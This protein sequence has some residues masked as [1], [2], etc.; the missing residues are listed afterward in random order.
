ML[1]VLLKQIDAHVGEVYEILEF[2]AGRHAN[3]TAEI[4]LDFRLGRELGVIDEGGL[5]QAILDQRLHLFLGNGLTPSFIITRSN[6][7]RVA[8]NAP[9]GRPKGKLYL[10]FL[11]ELIN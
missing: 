1:P 6:R 5:L 3:L 11:L 4:V 8:F 7:D 10:C 2:L 9:S